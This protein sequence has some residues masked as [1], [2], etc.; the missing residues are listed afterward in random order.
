MLR[1][2]GV[3]FSCL[4]F[5]RSRDLVVGFDRGADLLARR[6]GRHLA[7]RAFDREQTGRATWRRGPLAFLKLP[8]SAD[9]KDTHRPAV[10]SGHVLPS[11]VRPM[12][13]ARVFATQYA[14]RSSIGSPGRYDSCIILT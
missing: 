5:E 14:H 3:H 2:A 8:R 6:C 11:D 1:F 9:W 4:P 7:A 13:S 12:A 10:R